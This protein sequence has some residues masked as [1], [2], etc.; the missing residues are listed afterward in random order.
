MIYLTV[1]LIMAT[2]CTASPFSIKMDSKLGS[3]KLPS[4]CNFQQQ[5]R[6]SEC[7]LVGDTP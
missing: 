3:G 7:T 1:M 5:P 6:A 2:V 4:D